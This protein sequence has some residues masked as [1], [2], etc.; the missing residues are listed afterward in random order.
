MDYYEYV[1]A[2][3][4]Y[5]IKS[6]TWGFNYAENGVSGTNTYGA[7]ECGNA[8]GMYVG[9]YGEYVDNY[10]FDYT[11]GAFSELYQ[12]ITIPRGFVK[13]AYISFDYPVP[14]NTKD[15][16][17][18]ALL[19]RRLPEAIKK[20][21]SDLIIYNAGTDIFTEDALGGLSISAQGIIKRDELVFNNAMQNKIP[22][23]MLLAGGYSLKSAEIIGRSIENLIKPG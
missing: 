10:E 14:A 7:G 12:N 4:N 18:L 9:L 23:L 11:D 16:D 1:N 13:D 3:S 2:S 19:K 8:T 22:I 21:S 5:D 17:Y 20:A 15:S 6:D